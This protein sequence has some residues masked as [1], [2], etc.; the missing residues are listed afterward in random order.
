MVC[1]IFLNTFKK[2]KTH[3]FR[4][5]CWKKNEKKMPDILQELQGSGE[6]SKQSKQTKI[7]DVFAPHCPIALFVS[8]EGI[9]NANK[10]R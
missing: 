8:E 10:T 9:G 2:K 6:K 5:K 4:N 3:T 7:T 1:S